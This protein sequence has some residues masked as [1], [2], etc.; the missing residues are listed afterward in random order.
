VEINACDRYGDAALHYNTL[1]QRAN[2]IFEK[3]NKLITR[4]QD[5]TL[6]GFSKSYK[7]NPLNKFDDEFYEFEQTENLEQLQV[8]YIRKNKREFIDK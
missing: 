4:H 5:G 2:E 3:E 6:K 7:H 1:T 8:E